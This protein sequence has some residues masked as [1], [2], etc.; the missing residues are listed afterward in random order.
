MAKG[1]YPYSAPFSYQAGVLFNIV[2]TLISEPSS[3]GRLNLFLGFIQT[4]SYTS[5][6]V[7][8]PS[9]TAP[10]SNGRRTVWF[11]MPYA[12]LAA[13]LSLLL[14]GAQSLAMMSI[15]SMFC[16]KYL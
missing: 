12:G 16:H 1:L 7:I 2:E 13:S 6:M 11:V 14:C 5:R 4:F 8:L 3:I 9:A 15:Q 10:N